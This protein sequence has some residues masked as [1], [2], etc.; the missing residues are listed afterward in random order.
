MSDEEDSFNDSYQPSTFVATDMKPHGS[1]STG[2]GFDAVCDGYDMEERLTEA[3]KM[4]AYFVVQLSRD[5]YLN[6]FMINIF[7]SFEH[8]IARINQEQR[9]AYWSHYHTIQTHMKNRFDFQKLQI[10]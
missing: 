10:L 3:H 5:T 7:P 1:L 6:D 2:I 8:W 9:P 4:E